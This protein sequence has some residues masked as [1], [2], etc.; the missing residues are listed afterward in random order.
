MKAGVRPA[1]PIRQAFAHDGGEPKSVT[2]QIPSFVIIKLSGFKIAVNNPHG[3]SVFQ[4][5]GS[6]PDKVQGLEGRQPTLLSEHF[7]QVAAI[8]EFHDHKP[9]AKNGILAKIIHV[10]DVGVTDASHGFGLGAEGL[11]EVSVATQIGREDLHRHRA[12][13]AHLL[14]QIDGSHAASANASL[15]CSSHASLAQ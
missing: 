1:H 5:H 15:D 8:D 10:Q 14:R 9:D 6:L 3:R 12:V 2:L 11:N 7:S 13:K 4:A